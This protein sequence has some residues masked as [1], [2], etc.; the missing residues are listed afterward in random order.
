MA[1][2]SRKTTIQPQPAPR[3]PAGQFDTSS[4]A[5]FWTLAVGGSFALMMPTL[6]AAL[7]VARGN[8]PQALWA[9]GQIGVATQPVALSLVGG[10][11]AIVVALMTLAKG[12]FSDRFRRSAP[13]AAAAIGIYVGVLCTAGALQNRSTAASLP[14]VYL[15]SIVVASLSV[16]VGMHALDSLEERRRRVTAILED[17][18]RAVALLQPPAETTG[19]LRRFSRRLVIYASCAA[20]IGVL[21]MQAI[22]APVLD[23]SDWA[24]ILF[25][26]VASGVCAAATGNGAFVAFSS[27]ATSRRTSTDKAGAALIFFVG[28]APALVPAAIFILSPTV[29]WLAAPFIAAWLVPV[30]VAAPGLLTRRRLRFALSNTIFDL[31]YSRELDRFRKAKAEWEAL[32]QLGDARG[33]G[34]AAKSSRRWRLRFAP[35]WRERLMRTVGARVAGVMRRLVPG[36]RGRTPQASQDAATTDL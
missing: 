20:S 21:V 31:T 30:L 35:H 28:S 26:A 27:Y 24:F 1:T 11:I 15:A 5:R 32:S 16:A 14:A 22:S 3:V 13:P 33:P 8:T 29:R 10:P 34:L 9:V 2:K 17:S 18:G 19:S 23:G 6:L 7:L 36:R 12:A 25:L 4:Q